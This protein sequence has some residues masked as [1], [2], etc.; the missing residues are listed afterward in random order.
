MPPEQKSN[1]SPNGSSAHTPYTASLTDA[2]L[3]AGER[4]SRAPG[5]GFIVPTPLISRGKP[6]FASVGNA[7]AVNDGVYGPDSSWNAGLPSPGSPSWVAIHVGVGPKRVFVSWTASGN[8]NY[9]DTREGAPAE[10]RLE[11]SADSTN[12]SDGSWRVEAL[13]TQ[14]R[15]RA[16]AH[17]FEFDGR[18]WVRLTVTV[19]PTPSS[20]IRI[21][22]IDV[23]DAT[24]GA[25]DTWFFLGDSVTAFA[26]S[27]AA[28]SQPSF[29]ENVHAEYP[30]Y[31]PVMI[32]GGIGGELTTGGLAR[33]RAVLALNPDVRFFAIGY[34]TNDAW[35]GRL[36]PAQFR[37]NLQSMIDQ[38][39][40]A[41]RVPVL[42]RIPFSPDGNHE[43]LR[44][45]NHVLDALTREN[46]LL[47]G[48]DLYG[49]FLGH[50]E[51]LTDNVHP[52]PD[53]RAAINR[54]WAEAMD[55]LYVP[56]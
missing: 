11:S 38:L 54:L 9:T 43:T 52:G 23:H 29:A 2:P 27:R 18:S 48:P 3:F 31:F 25:D 40:D 14:N 37:S 35:G 45:Y 41:G 32:N 39:L 30:G 4:T 10:Y 49:W 16:R 19:A 20:G 50:P 46:H 55:P 22:E 24:D 53:G 12:G 5:V 7:R 42:A 6:V 33:L 8:Y 1:G 56:Q 21:D 44:A 15:V 51:Q 13:V 28:D 36:T 47:T 26:F 34:G 17:G